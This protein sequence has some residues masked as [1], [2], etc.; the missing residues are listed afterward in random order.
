MA[1]EKFHKVLNIATGSVT[2]TL[3]YY[4]EKGIPM[5]NNADTVTSPI[6]QPVKSDMT[7]LAIFKAD[8]AADTYIQLEHSFDGSTWVHQGEFEEDASV[9]HDD[10]SKNMAKISAIDDSLVDTREGMMMMYDIDS[11]GV[12]PYTRFVIKPNGQ[13]ES[14]NLCDFYLIPHF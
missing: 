4:S 5:G 1:W 9:D 14:S 7:I 12:A 11:H 6:P 13:N 10:I 8:I 2:M 3:G